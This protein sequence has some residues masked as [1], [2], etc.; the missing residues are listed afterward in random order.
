MFPAFSHD[1]QELLA[2]AVP[3]AASSD[4]P[5]DLGAGA[6]PAAFAAAA[7]AVAASGEADSLLLVV[8]GTRANV[9][10]GILAA[11]APVVDRYPALTV[12]AVV[13]GGNDD[14]P[15]LGQRHAPV[16]DLPEQAV[17]ALGHAARYAAWRREPLGRRPDLTGVDAD[18]ARVLVRDALA[19]ESRLAALRT[20]S[21][22]PRRVRYPDPATRP[23]CRLR[24]TR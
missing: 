1:L 22:D 21:G 19:V 24:T 4:N 15:S 23:P 13:V 6:S 17:V 20:H 5:L 11:L 14:A 10:A 2:E 7:E 3:G 18:A 8:I 12:A 9:P 16:F